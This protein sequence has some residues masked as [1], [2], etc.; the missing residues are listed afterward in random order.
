M[1]RGTKNS[2]LWRMTTNRATTP[3][4]SG[5]T[6]WPEIRRLG[7]RVTLGDIREMDTSNEK[8]FDICMHVSS[9][10][11]HGPLLPTLLSEGM[12][13]SVFVHLSRQH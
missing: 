6:Q 2:I 10:R 7:V 9:S 4:K 11:A 8:A 5:N 13:N 1:L 3:L 12:G